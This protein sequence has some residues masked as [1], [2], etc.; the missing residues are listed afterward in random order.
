MM[1]RVSEHGDRDGMTAR[2][3]QGSRGARELARPEVERLA[4]SATILTFVRTAAAVAF[5]LWGAREHSLGLLLVALAVYWL[6]DIADGVLAR[7]RDE[8]TRIGAVLDVLCDRASAAVF[9]VGFAWYDPTMAV[10]VGIYLAEFLVLDMFL[11]LAFLAWPVSSPNYFYVVD[12]PLWLWNWSKP[13]KAVNSALF[14]VVL[15]ATRQPVLTSVVALALLILKAVSL[16][17]LMHLGLP[18]PALDTLRRMPP[19]TA[20]AGAPNER[21]DSPGVATASRDVS[22]P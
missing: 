7:A 9:Y 22:H 11:S 21:R 1:N 5:A 13:G 16:R 20:Y 2:L 8:E 6:G 4:T 17:R 3:R 14:A 12:R 15:V 18:I 10:P 19:P